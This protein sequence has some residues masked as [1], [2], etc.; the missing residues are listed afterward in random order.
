MVS[1]LLAAPSLTL[2][3]RRQLKELMELQSDPV[4]IEEAVSWAEPDQMKRTTLLQR[5]MRMTVV[6][7]VHL[8]LK[9]SR[10]ERLALIRD[11]CKVVQRAVLQ[12]AKITDREIEAYAAMTILSEEVLR[13]IGS[14]RKYRKNYPVVKNLL[15]NPKTPL[16]VSLHLLPSITAQDLNLLCT[17]KNIPDTLRTMALRLQRQRALA[18]PGGG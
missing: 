7:R 5:L 8:A 14:N 18:R 2:D 3:Q 12:S 17:N 11:P 4:I 10:E 16:D 9:G 13:I 15:N 1:A 6:E